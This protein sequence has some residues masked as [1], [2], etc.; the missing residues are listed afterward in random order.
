MSD[1]YPGVE[2]TVVLNGGQRPM[3]S[4]LA[5][6]DLQKICCCLLNIACCFPCMGNRWQSWRKN[7]VCVFFP[8]LFPFVFSSQKDLTPPYYSV[9]VH[10]QPPLKPYEE[11]VYGTGPGLMPPTHPHY[12]P[13]YPPPVVGPHVTRSSIRECQD[14]VQVQ[15]CQQSKWWCLS[16]GC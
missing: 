11:V 8:C 12:I 3:C 6:K 13:Q 4:A 1:F 9:A 14:V 2:V 15:V 10:T 7:I 16:R 5:T